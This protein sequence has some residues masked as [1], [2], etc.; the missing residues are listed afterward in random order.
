MKQ[1]GMFFALIVICIFGISTYS[2]AIVLPLNA[3]IQQQTNWCWASSAQ[4]IVRW[5]GGSVNQCTLADELRDASGWGYD[6]CCSYDFRTL[7]LW[8]ICDQGNYLYYWGYGARSVQEMLDD[9]GIDTTGVAGAISQST[10][11]TELNAGRPFITRWDWYQGGA[12]AQVVRGLEGNNIFYFD[13]W[14]LTNNFLV[15]TYNYYVYGPLHHTWT[16]T[17]RTDDSPNPPIVDIKVN[18]YGG[19]Y[20]ATPSTYLNI[21]VRLTDGLYAGTQ[22]DWW[23]L[24]QFSSYLFYLNQSGN[25]TTTP[26]TWSQSDLTDRYATILSGTLGTGVY[27]I[28]FGVDLT[29]DGAIDDPAYYDYITIVVQ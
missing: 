22:A 12:H 7:Q 26:S 5:L 28:Y 21:T 16:R 8:H 18:G 9:R 10:V 23:V 13:P 2:E 15:N 27:T 14:P 20:Y 17:L 25:W 3:T 19:T 24:G 29:R 1:R 11:Q 6:Q 4:A